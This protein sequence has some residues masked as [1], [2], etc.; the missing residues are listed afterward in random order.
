MQATLRRRHYSRR[1]EEAYLYWIRQF[2]R[3]HHMP[4]L[5]GLEPARSGPLHGPVALDSAI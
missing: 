2:I 1:T 3:F 5:S 4:E